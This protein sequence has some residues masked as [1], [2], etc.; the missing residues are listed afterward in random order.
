MQ[1]YAEPIWLLLSQWMFNQ[2]SFPGWAPLTGRMK[3]KEVSVKFKD[4]RSWLCQ[5]L[6][7]LL[8]ASKHFH[9]SGM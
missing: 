2:T 4:T 9:L 8:I 6:I 1:R 7:I 3:L 5:Y